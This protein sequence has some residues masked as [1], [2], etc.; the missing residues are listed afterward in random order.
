[1]TDRATVLTVAANT[2][3]IH[4]PSGWSFGFQGDSAESWEW[5]RGLLKRADAEHALR[6]LSLRRATS[7]HCVWRTVP[8]HE[9]AFRSTGRR[10][11]NQ[12]GDS[13]RRI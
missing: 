4:L 3:P 6:D 5:M 13:W 9:L 8:W 10:R 2:Q 12:P 7:I 1:L 11:R